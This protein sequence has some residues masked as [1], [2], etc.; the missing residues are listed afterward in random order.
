MD[1][2][3]HTYNLHF[4]FSSLFEDGVK[5]EK[6]MVSYF[7]EML[8]YQ[9]LLLVFMLLLDVRFY[10]CERLCVIGLEGV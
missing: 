10:R 7:R 6:E 8:S 9:G 1:S 5:V 4:E 3:L 2:N